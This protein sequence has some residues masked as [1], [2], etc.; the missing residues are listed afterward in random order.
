MRKW[1]IFFLTILM[2]VPVLLTAAA[3]AIPPQYGE[4]YLGELKEKRERLEE[5]EEE[6]IIVAGGSS[7]AFGVR[8]D[9]ME[10]ELGMPVANWGLYAPLGSRTML[11]ACLDEVGEGDIVVFSPEQ[12]PETLSLSFQA[13]QVWQAADSDRS[14][15]RVFHGEDWKSLTGAFPEFA[16]SKLK[17]A[18]EGKPETD[19]IYRK[20][21]FNQ[22]GDIAAERE[23]NQMSGGYDAAQ[24]IDFSFFPDAEFTDYLNEYAEKVRKKGGEFYYRL[25]PMNREA[26]VDEGEADAWFRRMDEK[27]DFILLGDPHRSIMDSEWFYDTNFHLNDS[28]AVVNTYYFVRDIKAQTEDPT[29][30]DIELPEKPA[31]LVKTD[32][33]GDDSDADCFL[34]E[35][36][37]GHLVITG[38]TDE[39][40]QKKELTLPQRFEGRTVAAVR[41]KSLAECPALECVHVYGGMTL[42]DGCFEGCDALQKIVLH[43]K[44]SEIT[45]GRNLL[46]GCRAS[47][48]TEYT[49]EYRVDY[50]WAQ[51]SD[52]I[53]E[54]R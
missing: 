54:W 48:Y 51:Y 42:Y 38:V 23:G 29:P 33:Q 7:A 21:S 47:L 6:K 20:D 19:G 25:C 18:L 44:P 53:K 34:Y 50:S 22:Y 52:R 12:N 14:L 46:K 27:A 43:A 36:E 15:L 28:G 45:A 3:F 49:D 32:M 10:E 24:M 35:E 40:K 11:D 8:S 13:E 1:R 37:D 16:V 30:T 17:Y 4:T 41:E 2:A 5:T 39:G 9:L 31:A 26:V